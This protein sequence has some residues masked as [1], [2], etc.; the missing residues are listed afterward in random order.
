VGQHPGTAHSHENTRTRIALHGPA[1]KIIFLGTC[2]M[3]ATVYIG[4]VTREFFADYF[5][6]KLDL[7]SLQMAARLEPGNA[8]YQYRLGHYFLQ[9]QHEPETAMQFFKS[10]TALNPHNAGY[11]LELSRIYR[12]LAN[13]D[14]QKDAL[15]HAIAVDPSTPDV[16]WDAANFYWALGETDKSLQEFRVALQS[17]PNSA[18]SFERC[19]QIKPD[20]D[21][22][23]SDVVPR[24]AEAYSSF[25]DF[26][27]SKNQP[28]AAAR[29]WTQMVQLQQTVEPRHVFDYVRYL[30]DQ[31]EVGQAHQAWLQAASLCDLSGYQPSSENLVVNGDFSLPVLNGGFDWLYEKSSDVS[32]ALDPTESRSGHRSLSIIFDSRGIE[33]AGIRQLIP[34]EPNARYE[35]SAYF[36]SEG[37][38]GA[39]GPRFLLADRFTGANYFASEELKDAGFWKQVGGTFDTGPDAKLLVLRIQRVPAGNAIRGK[40]WIGDVRLALVHLAH[41]HLTQEQPT[42]GGQ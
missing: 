35:F 16:A 31:R 21:L 7:P 30:I 13:G 10:A 5:S 12:R 34:V 1:R 23:L 33:D 25:L 9:T 22:L 26:L 20:V 29:V 11:W 18:A 6:R 15:Q 39:G 14:Q 42:A 19:W 2:L 24:N 4:W 32:L 38:E 8:D 28:A 27:I 36:K 3:F 40:L 17:D 37:L 41:V